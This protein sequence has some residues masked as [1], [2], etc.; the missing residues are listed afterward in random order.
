MTKKNKISFFLLDDDATFNFIHRKKI[1]KFGI[2]QEIKEF[3]SPRKALIDL[4]D[5]DENHIPDILLLDINMP[6]LTGFEFIDALADK[7]PEL[8]DKLNIFIVTS[9]LN[10]EDHQTAKGYDCI[11]GFHDKPIDL[12]KIMTTFNQL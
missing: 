6:E 12:D 5:V 7:R 4:M 10:P 8:L 2:E 3:I 1:E 9:S 11:K